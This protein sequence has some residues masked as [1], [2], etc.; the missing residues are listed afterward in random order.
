MQTEITL[1]SFAETV[2]RMRA[3]QKNWFRYHSKKDLRESMQLEKLVDDQI[4]L[5]L[6]GKPIVL[7]QN[8][9]L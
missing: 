2:Q 3:A 8:L 5:I 1:Q 9:F 4:K 6:D 7:Q